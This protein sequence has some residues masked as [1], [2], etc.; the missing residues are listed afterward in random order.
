M[1]EKPYNVLFICTGNSARS[2]LAEVSLNQIGAGRFKA[3]SAGSHPRGE[4]HPL[5][6]EVLAGQ[7]YA[8][9]GLRS[10]GWN[11]FVGADAPTMDFIFTV[12]DQAAGELCPAW[13]GQPVT[14]H[15]DFADPSKVTG[16]REAQLKA[17]KAA[18]S[19]IANRIRLFLS[20]PIDK[21][22]RASLQ[23]QVRELGASSKA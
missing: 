21:L 7:G 19:Q 1:T 18:Q 2:I 8:I 23:A 14:A 15:W 20:L 4:I 12:C 5:T 3:Y 10:K 22:D 6:L 9:D 11:E 16:E 17:F 13:P